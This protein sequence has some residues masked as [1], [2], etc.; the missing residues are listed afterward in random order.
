[1]HH[2]LFMVV[3]GAIVFSGAVYDT[4]KKSASRC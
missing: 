4:T 3:L 1:M 2:K